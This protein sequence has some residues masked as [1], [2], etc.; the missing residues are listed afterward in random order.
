M[1]PKPTPVAS[2]EFGTRKLRTLLIDESAIV[3]NMMSYFLGVAGFFD[4]VATVDNTKDG[5]DKT[6]ELTP[7]LVIMD[8]TTRGGSATKF[9]EA[10][11]DLAI[12]PK[13]ILLCDREGEAPRKK[14]LAAGADA[15]IYKLD[16]ADVLLP[17]IFKLFPD[18]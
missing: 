13:I 17:T 15:Y 12:P 11:K 5:F 6:I 2:G 1:V 4:V 3:R 16:A 18:L 8:M 9:T 14:A 7:D 10:M